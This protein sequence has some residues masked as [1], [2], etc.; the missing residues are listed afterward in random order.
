M[1]N[2]LIYYNSE[3]YF[4]SS[5]GNII[6]RDALICKPQAVEIPSG[7]CVIEKESIIR[8][9]FAAV[10]L[11][12]YCSIGKRA[13]IRPSFVDLK[14]FKFIPMT[15]G[16][17]SFIG[18]DCVIESAVIGIGCYI[19]RNS[20]LSKRSILKDFVYV[21]ENAVVPPGSCS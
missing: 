8:G 2:P 12:K 10:T 7:R 3:E 19:G 15:I 13:V 9:D 17:H 20:V 6:S 16:S 11:N 21:M 4:P 14:G 5:N 1:Y 18:D